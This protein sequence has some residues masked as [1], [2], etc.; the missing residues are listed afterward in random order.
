MRT[1]IFVTAILQVKYCNT[2]ICMDIL[3]SNFYS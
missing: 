3:Q 2:A 1:M